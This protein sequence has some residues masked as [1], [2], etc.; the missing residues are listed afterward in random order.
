[1]MLAQGIAALMRW[2]CGWVACWGLWH[3]RAWVHWAQARGLV[4][5]QRCIVGRHVHMFAFLR[6]FACWGVGVCGRVGELASW[7]IWGGGAL[8]VG[9][10]LHVVEVGES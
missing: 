1:M 4:R 8:E 6:V 5:A 7:R 10:L 2:G 9:V 3:T